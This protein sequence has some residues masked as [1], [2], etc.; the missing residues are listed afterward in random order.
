MCVCE[1]YTIRP[2]THGS[3][4]AARD[5]PLRTEGL[6]GESVVHTQRILYAHHSLSRNHSMAVP[7]DHVLRTSEKQG[8]AHVMK[9]FMVLGTVPRGSSSAGLSTDVVLTGGAR[10]DQ[11]SQSAIIIPSDVN[12]YI[13][14]YIYRSLSLSLSLSFYI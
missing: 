13:Y 14:I 12:V 9:V 3:V 6:P 10:I 5:V 1:Y 4:S 7:E 11:C 8:I 2:C